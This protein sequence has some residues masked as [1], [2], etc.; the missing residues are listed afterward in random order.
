MVALFVQ[1]GLVSFAAKFCYVTP[2]GAP[3]MS[4]RAMLENLNPTPEGLSS[5]VQVPNGRSAT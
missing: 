3:A 5:T 1:R 4:S 2:I